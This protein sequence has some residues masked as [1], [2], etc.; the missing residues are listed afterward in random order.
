VVDV[1]P[2]RSWLRRNTILVACIAAGVLALTYAVV[3]FTRAMTRT[4]AVGNTSGPPGSS[5]P[6]T[7]GPVVGPSASPS[8][9]PSSSATP[10]PTK[11][12]RPSSG[13]SPPTSFPGPGNTGPRGVS[14]TTY[15]GPCTITKANTVISGKL[16]RCGKLLNKA[17]N[18]VIRKS[19]VMGPIE[20]RGSATIR[21]EDTEVDAGTAYEAAVGYENVTMFRS[22]IHGAETSVNCHTNCHIQDSW[23]H[24]QYIPPGEDWHLDAYLSNGGHDVT[25]IHNTLACDAQQTSNGGGCSA[26]AA[27]FGDFAP[28]ANYRFERNLFVASTEMPYCTYAGYQTNKP[29]GQQ[30]S[31]IVYRYNVFQRGSNGKCG[32]YGTVTSYRQEPGSEFVGNVYDDGTPV[33]PGG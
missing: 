6:G 16:V 8:A 27:I 13:Q 3:V 25:L 14:L 18:L 5:T 20:N 30:V 10:K 1:P 9:S 19:K 31:G 28:N 29:Y 26:N 7:T 24:G 32:Y 17:K 21:I 15:S 4:E 22:N 33:K 12:R 23:L 11:T 2:R